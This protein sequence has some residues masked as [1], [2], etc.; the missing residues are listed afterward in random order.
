MPDTKRTRIAGLAED[1]RYALRL[2]RR[3]PGHALVTILTLALGVGAATALFSVAFGVLV[4]PLPWREADRLVRVFET[5]P[6]GTNRLGPIVTNAS[7]LPVR[8]QSATLDGLEGW[9]NETVTVA[10]A[11]E[12]VRVRIARVTPGLFPLLGA[13]PLI[14]APFAAG[15]ERPGSERRVLLSHGFWQ[16]R[17]GGAPGVLGRAVRLDGEPHRVAGVMPAWFDFPDR[18]ARAWAPLDV[19]PV[20]GAEPGQRRLSIFNAVGRLRPGVTPA[21]AAAE[22]TTRARTGPDPGM[23]AVAVF[24]TKAPVEL[25]VVPWL[26]A[27]TADVRPALLV[28]LAA[29][30]LLLVTAAANV[31]GVQLARMTARRREIAIRS[32][33]GAGGIRLTRQFLVENAVLGLAGG[34]AGLGLAAA[35]HR[36]LPLLLPPDFPRTD[37]VTL[38][39][40][41]AAFALAITLAASLAVGLMPALQAR[42]FDITQS[43]AEDGIAPV[44]AGTRT[45]AGRA[46]AIIMAG[47]LAIACILLVGAA[48]LARS[49]VAL[50]G[51]DRGYDPTGV[52]TARLSLPD[53]SYTPLRR[54]D[55]LN[56]LLARVRAVPGVEAA[57]FTTSLPLTPGETLAGF[58]MRSARTGTTVAVQAA[59]RQVSPGF[60]AAL[61]L[62]IVQGRGFTEQ[63]AMASAPVVVV[64]EAFARQ[65]LDDSPVGERIP[66]TFLE[67]YTE[68]E[69]VG[70][71]ADV[72][73]RSVT[74]PA[75][76]EIYRSF[77]QF[78]QG[79]LHD[80]PTLAIRTTTDPGRFAPILRSLVR[81]LDPTLA[82]DSVMTM[83]ARVGTSL[84]R[85][86]LYAVLLGS[87]AFFALAVAGVG[88]FGALAYSVAQRSREIGVRTTLGA[89]PGT[90]V[91]MVVGQGLRIAVAGIVLGL[92]TSFI[93]ARSLAAFLY[94]VQPHDAASFALVPVLLVL[95]ALAACVVPARRAARVDP[96]RVLKG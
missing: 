16:E 84:A 21:Q 73:H 41:V 35:L 94:G 80:E 78:S 67:G 29:V 59:I 91:R 68:A 28:F 81:D 63:D 96:L 18:N 88:L 47:Q 22:G 26:E 23:V 49:F 92:V 32:A 34:L 58:P 30:G 75:H 13:Q 1:I 85:P 48:L 87:F 11:G 51:A 89:T 10:G 33:L 62:R 43:L 86:R 37:A 42:R 61:R 57:G 82:L 46:R 14:G 25:Q 93:V 7:Y 56:T 76:P 3:Q 95:V 77:R 83:D 55:A 4:R 50:L 72:H 52:L 39:L 2:M 70:V 69:V 12:P 54:A 20:I 17:F 9:S 66:S 65:Y 64:N 53:T 79:L 71:V 15:D 19:P 8:E 60:F 27:Q 24:G 36:A 6:G 44:G 31:A 74:D 38:D 45:R 90:I 40:V 5:R